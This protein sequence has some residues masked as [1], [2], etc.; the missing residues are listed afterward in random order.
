VTDSRERS[1]RCI[2][3]CGT[4][5]KRER[6]DGQEID[7]GGGGQKERGRRDC[8]GRVSLA[9]RGSGVRERGGGGDGKG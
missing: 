8:A 6:N 1:R 4:E 5:K 3:E 7:N 2:A 9:H